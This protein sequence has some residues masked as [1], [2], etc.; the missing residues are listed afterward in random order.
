MIES[1]SEDAM[2]WFSLHFS[3]DVPDGHI[4]HSHRY[5]PLA[6]APW[7][8]IL[9]EYVPHLKWIDDRLSVKKRV[10]ISS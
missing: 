3:H 7:F 1:L 8:L 6:M 9:H 2:K 4:E 5:R 10:R